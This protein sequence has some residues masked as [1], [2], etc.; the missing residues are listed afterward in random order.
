MAAPDAVTAALDAVRYWR[1]MTEL[2]RFAAERHGFG[3]TDGGF[4]VTYPDDL[5]EYDRAVEGTFIP[6]GFVRVYGFWGPPDGYERL[7][8]E[9]VYLRVLADVLA[10]AGHMAEAAAVRALATRLNK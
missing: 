1:P 5:D 3:D 10:G 4:G 9:A 8:P 2:A 7:V 6:P